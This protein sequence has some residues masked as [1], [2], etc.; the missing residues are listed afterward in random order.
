MLVSG[1]GGAFLFVAFFLLA[2]CGGA[3]CGA[4][5]F[6]YLFGGTFGGALFGVALLDN[7]ICFCLYL[8][9]QFFV[10]FGFSL[11]AHSCEAFVGICVVSMFL[12]YLLH[13]KTKKKAPI[14]Q[15]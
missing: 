2:H 7:A 5:L 3:L 1:S 11:A 13:H 14:K 9:Q 12:L 4:F 8:V 15:F 10:S 6:L